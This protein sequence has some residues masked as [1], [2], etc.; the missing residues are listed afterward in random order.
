MSFFERSYGL[1]VNGG[2]FYAVSGDM[3]IKQSVADSNSSNV[4]ISRARRS[5]TGAARYT[6]YN[7]SDFARPQGQLISQASSRREA[8][9]ET[10]PKSNTLLPNTSR[11]TTFDCTPFFQYLP[12]YDFSG[13]TMSLYPSPRPRL[14]ESLAHSPVSN[15]DLYSPDRY[16]PVDLMPHQRVQ[17][18]NDLLIRLTEECPESTSGYMHPEYTQPTT[19]INGGTFVSHNS[20][21]QSEKGINT[22]HS[23]AAL[24]ALNDSAD[25]FP[26]PRCHPETRTKMLDD[27]R[28]WS[29]EEDTSSRILWLFG[30]AGAGKSAIM[31]TLSRQLQ[32]AGQLGG[33]FFFK[34]AHPTRGNAKVLFVTIA[35]QLALGVSWLKAPILQVVEEDPSVV[36]RSIDTQ[37]QKLIS[38]PCRTVRSNKNPLLILIDGLDECEG[39]DI[40]QGILRA[41]RNS[42]TEHVLPLRFIIASRPEPH[43]RE[44]FESP[45]Y[46]GIYRPFN[47]EQSFDD[48]KKYFVNEFARIHREHHQTMSTVPLPWP[49]PD[50]LHKL[51]RTS[52]GYF[53]YA[54]T[55]I[56]FI[57][58]KNYRP[59]E[60]LAVVMKDQTESDSAYEALDR[61]YINIL[62]I[63][64][65]A[66]HPQLIPILCTLANFDLPPRVLDKLLELENGDTR[67]FLRGLHSVYKVPS[68]EYEEDEYGWDEISVHH[69]SFHDF[70]GDPKRS[71]NFYVGGLHHRMDL[72]RSIL[73][74]LARGYQ[75][76]C[77]GGLNSRSLPGRPIPFITSLPPSA[78]LLPL[79]RNV[80]PDYITEFW[81]EP[82][83]KMLTWMKKIH[84]APEDLIQLWEDYKY[85]S[86]I[87]WTLDPPFMWRP[88]NEISLPCAHHILSQYPRLLH[89]LCIL[90]LLRNSSISV[91][92][93]LL[94]IS[95][96]DLRSTV[97]GLRSIIGEDEEM[98]IDL[99]NHLR[100]PS[101]TGEI[102]PWPSVSRYIARRS[103]HIAK[104]FCTGERKDV[105]GSWSLMRR[106]CNWS[107]QVRLSLPCHELLRDLWSFQSLSQLPKCDA[108]DIYHILKWLESFPV[109]R[110][111]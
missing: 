41:I 90:M 108:E 4:Q 50:V 20:Q 100:H 34:R 37:L 30:P 86:F 91:T 5:V 110:S 64:P 102:F 103:I 60:R 43:I 22:L 9:A 32:N 16:L 3:N 33:C 70:L 28:R 57:D 36:A 105:G 66:Q 79:I 93:L 14:S 99:C 87:A 29:L 44:I 31:R 68:E 2:S 98:V 25:S 19:T 76:Q 63:A 92:R 111:K 40:H 7:Y 101:F 73:K 84:P 56:K 58:D 104:E 81:P 27:L 23:V 18:E 67:L 38:E 6:P 35:Y 83:E 15:P 82:L 69:A 17:R 65:I 106:H 88:P 1:Q 97:C 12:K 42:F 24:E 109:P 53:I 59:T 51:V 74:L 39:Q 10:S 55:I 46:H 52:S 89:F 96:S 48:V 78:E 47:V 11:V 72:A 107:L 85:M 21:H 13:A 77:I 95:W 45:A 75:E 8:H 80:N 49:L 71:Q 61:L 94:D 62:S 54:S 26:Q